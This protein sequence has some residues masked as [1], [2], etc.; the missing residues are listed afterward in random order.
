MGASK[1]LLIYG[2]LDNIT[3]DLLNDEYIINKRNYIDGLMSNDKDIDNSILNT[4]LS[5]FTLKD[6]I[7]NDEL[8]DVYKMYNSVV[9]NAKC[10]IEKSILTV[11]KDFLRDD[12]FNKR[13]TLM[14][15]LITSMRVEN[16]YLC[17]LLYIL[18]VS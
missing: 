14:N 6:Y 11:V 7:L 2:I 13:M 12:L 15:L 9:Y 16:E 10:L 3:V 18:F 5:S 8:A 17:Y 4:L 1:K